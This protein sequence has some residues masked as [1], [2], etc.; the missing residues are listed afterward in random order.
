MLW[1]DVTQNNPVLRTFVHI[2]NDLKNE[3]RGQ[4]NDIDSFSAEFKKQSIPLSKGKNTHLSSGYL[5]CKNIRGYHDEI[6][7]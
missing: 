3:K 6:R 5:F 4:L 1:L 2:L 7:F